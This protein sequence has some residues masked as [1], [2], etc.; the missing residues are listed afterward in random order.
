MMITYVTVCFSS[1]SMLSFLAQTNAHTQIYKHH[2]IQGSRRR[3]IW[4]GVALG[5]AWNQPDG[6][7][8]HVRETNACTR[9]R[10]SQKITPCGQRPQTLTWRQ[11]KSVSLKCFSRICHVRVFSPRSR[12]WQACNRTAAYVIHNP[13]YHL[14]QMSRFL[15][16]T[17]RLWSGLFDKVIHSGHLFGDISVPFSGLQNI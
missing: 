1:Y 17:V 16:Q 11:R 3:D 10:I 13:L 14:N 8:R 6:R 9:G 15:H 4:S 7:L 2:N 5:W 12:V